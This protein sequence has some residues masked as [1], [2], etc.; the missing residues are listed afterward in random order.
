M[1][2]VTV[3][4]TATEL[5]V[6]MNRDEF[7]SREPELPPVIRRGL[8]DSPDW[9]APIDSQAGGTWTGMNAAGLVAC[10]TN[11]YLTTE[12]PPP[13]ATPGVM[14]RGGIIPEILRRGNMAEALTW[15][16]TE[17]DATHYMPFT[18]ILA[19]MDA[20]H[21]VGSPGNGKLLSETADAEWTLLSSSSWRTDK[22]IRWRE[23][24]FEQ[25]R[26][27]GENYRDGVPE[28]HLF[29]PAEQEQWAPFMER[30]NTHTRSIT[31]SRIC[32]DRDLALMRYW[33]EPT[34]LE[35]GPCEEVHL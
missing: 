19:C 25:W 16:H 34:P 23:L 10:L 9:V 30:P 14:T 28:F 17:L 31:Q 35:L 22:V 7:R 29:Q 27:D 33:A 2:T 20:V 5:L 11:G 21:I 15:L 6:T 24:V 18:L 13:H 26:R 32:P 1:C 4:R 8:G 12:D 3:R